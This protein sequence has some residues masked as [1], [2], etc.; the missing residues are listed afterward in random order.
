[1]SEPTDMSDRLVAV[2][3]RIHQERMNDVPILNP[4]LTVEAIGTRAWNGHWLSAL[5]TPWFINLM[6][7]PETEEIAAAWKTLKL[8]AKTLHR[9]PSGRFEF[10]VGEE[11]E[12]GRYQMCSLFSPVLE[13]EGQEAARL[14]A[15]AALDALF[16]A[17]L[18]PA[19]E[20]ADA[21]AGAGQT[22]PAATTS[23]DGRDA[24]PSQPSRRG[25]LTGR[26]ASREDPGR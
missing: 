14:A 5:V 11:G 1:M 20:P 6:L 18:D 26:L 21:K 8:G 7:L 4:R 19:N 2:F 22:A 9:F 16:D 25:F 10:I 12:L 23:A 13:F 17:S 24:P 15:E 3:R